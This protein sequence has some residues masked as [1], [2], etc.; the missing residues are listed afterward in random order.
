MKYRILLLLALLFAIPA[1]AAGGTLAS[2]SCETAISFSI[3]PSVGS[4]DLQATQPEATAIQ[5]TP[6]IAAEAGK[7]TPAAEIQPQQTEDTPAVTDTEAAEGPE[8]KATEEPK[9]AADAVQEPLNT[10]DSEHA[11]ADIEGLAQQ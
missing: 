3:E 11:A 9:E 2:Y 4:M 6:Q 7:R 10:P 1:A 8:V 5:E